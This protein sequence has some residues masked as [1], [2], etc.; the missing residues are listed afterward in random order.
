[1]K[2]RCRQ[3]V[4]RRERIEFMTYIAKQP[5]TKIETVTRVAILCAFGLAGI[6]AADIPYSFSCDKSGGFL[7]NPG[8]QQRVG[9]ITDFNVTQGSGV[10]AALQTDLKVFVPF[11]P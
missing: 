10:R 9:Y 11:Y 3:S 8:Q 4:R 7:P 6:Q 2:P 5:A 1:M